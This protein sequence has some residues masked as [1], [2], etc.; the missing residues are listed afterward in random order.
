MKSRGLTIA[1]ALVVGAVLGL[2]AAV[3]GDGQSGG[4]YEKLASKRGLSPGE[5]EAALATFTPPGEH[6]E[7]LMFASGGHSGQ[8]YVI[9]VPSMQLLKT[10]PV[11]S[12]DAWSGYG[13]GAD[14]GEAV[15]GAGTDP[16][17]NDPL[18][19]GDA[20]HPAISETKGDYDGRW[21][22]INDRAN[23]RMGMVDLRDFKTKQIIDVP[24]IRSSH[25]GM[26]VT[27][28]TDYVHISSKT[29]APLWG[30]GTDLSRY[31]DEYRGVS[32][33]V[34]VDPKSGQGDLAKSFQIEL[35]PYNQD[36]ADAGKLTSDGFGFINTYNTEMATGGIQE[37]KEPLE[38]GSTKNDFDFLHIIDWR[39]AA[40]VVEAGKVEQVGGMRMIR[41]QTAIDE[42]ILHFA[43]EPRNPHGVDV[44][45][46]GDYITVAGK[47]DPST[48]VYDIE[49]IKK[50]IAA[51]SYSGR[52]PFGVPI[53]ALD[54]V[55]AGTVE[56]GAGPLHTQYDSEGNAFTSLFVESAVAKWTLG[57]KAGVAKDQA[58]KLVDKV[59]VHYNIGHVVTAEGDTVSPDG[60]YLVALNKWSV[61]RFPTVGTLHPQNFQLI[62]LTSPK[63]RILKDMPIGFAEPHYVQMIKRDKLK[64]WDVYPPGTDPKTMAGSDV[65]T[66]P[67]KE[68]VERDG[69]TVHVYMTAMRSH[70]NPDI[71]RVKEGD[72][73][74]M[75]I[76]NIERAKDA[77]H[78]F[79][80]P[81]HNVQASL[82]PGEVVTVEFDAKR[83]GSFGFYCTEFCS[84]LHLEMQG[85]L[86]VEPA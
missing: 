75:H 35:P 81:G 34:A 43:P 72:H 86:L 3:V 78:G 41:L 33:W 67:G 8:M 54:K 16:A 24:N 32:T 74:V 23:G 13:Y 25:G 51:K 31:Q 53:L 56:V 61:D 85:W 50:A 21:L 36:L 14:A 10:I 65:A 26:F 52:D 40:E 45:P 11:F 76:T 66:E 69:T 7:Y 83:T 28:N 38:I 22:Y 20:H 5:A 30:P 60:K 9:G 2:G 62:D 17:K 19:W 6:D 37:G 68:R 18:R 84:A 55:L 80:I 47:L 82:D 44:N 29:P 12:P 73:V 59:S 57:P 71:V 42:G 58:F 77:T 39:K 49:L 15:L 70:F 4:R 63:M 64:A 79:A 46:T 48:Y 1:V 27:P